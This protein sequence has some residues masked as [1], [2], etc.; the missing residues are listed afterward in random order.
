M[1]YFYCEFIFNFHSLKLLVVIV[2]LNFTHFKLYTY[3]SSPVVVAEAILGV[4]LL[5]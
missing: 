2:G 5:T 3:G 1:R 4:Y